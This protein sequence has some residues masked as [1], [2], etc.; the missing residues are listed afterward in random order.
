MSGVSSMASVVSLRWRGGEG[1]WLVSSGRCLWLHSQG[2]ARH[3]AGHCSR[4]EL[5]VSIRNIQTPTAISVASYF[6]LYPH[7]MLPLAKF[8][9]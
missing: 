4:E 2:S 5:P 8:D 3:E 9:G 1:A 7:E 6:L